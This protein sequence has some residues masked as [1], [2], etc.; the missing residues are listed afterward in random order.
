MQPRLFMPL[1][2]ILCDLI[3]HFASIVASFAPKVNTS[4]VLDEYFAE[5]IL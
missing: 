4:D 1:G 2:C 3:V 5:C